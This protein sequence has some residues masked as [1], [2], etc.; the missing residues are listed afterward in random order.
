[1]PHLSRKD[2]RWGVAMPKMRFLFVS[3][4]VMPALMLASCEKPASKQQTTSVRSVYNPR[5]T[6]APLALPTPVNAYRSGDGTPG[7]DYWQNR[8][9]YKIA[10]TLDP[11]NA[12]ISGDETITYTNNSPS[13][14]TALWLQL[15]ENTYKKDARSRFAAGA[16][17]RRAVAQ[18]TDGFV[19]DA[20]EIGEGSQAHKVDYVVSDTRMQVRLPD[21]LKARGGQIKLHIRYHYTVPAG[22][23]GRTGHAPTKNGEI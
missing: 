23:S 11:A 9:D 22:E 19:L 12:S 13:A 21:A 14:L 6:F 1:M 4:A 20:V 3:M 2:E 7:P 5:Q 10:A 15:D 17:R 8:A 16:G 18:T